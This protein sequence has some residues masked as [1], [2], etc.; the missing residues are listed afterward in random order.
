VITCELKGHRDYNYIRILLKEL[1][2]MAKSG[3]LSRIPP[4]EDEDFI[5]ALSR[6]LEELKLLKVKP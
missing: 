5:Y 3:R 4:E 2:D 6:G 1:I